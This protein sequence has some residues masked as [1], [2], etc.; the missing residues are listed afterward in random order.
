M[1]VLLEFVG[2]LGGGN[3]AAWGWLVGLGGEGFE[4]LLKI[5]H[6][7]VIIK[8]DKYDKKGGGVGRNRR[9]EFSL[10][11]YDGCNVLNSFISAVVYACSDQRLMGKDAKESLHKPRNI[12]DP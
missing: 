10:F 2:A 11:L 12:K 4:V 9:V 3:A 6:L 7:T 5:A 1:K 8:I